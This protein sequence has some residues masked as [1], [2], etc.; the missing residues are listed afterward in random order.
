[1]KWLFGWP[2]PDK[3]YVVN[4]PLQRLRHEM[5]QRSILRALKVNDAT[6]WYWE[7][8]SHAKGP[9]KAILDG[10]TGEDADGWDR[11]PARTQERLKAFREAASLEAC[12]DRAGI[13]VS[14]Y[15]VELREAERRG[16]KRELLQYLKIEGPF[17]VSRQGG[18]VA[19]KLFIPTQIMLRFREQAMK[20]G[21]KQ[22]VWLLKGLPGFDRWF[23]DWTTPK[24]Y[25]GKRHQ[26]ALSHAELPHNRPERISRNATADADQ[27]KKTGGRPSDSRTQALYKFC[28]R[29]YVTEDKGAATVMVLAN[30]LF[31]D[32]TIEEEATVRQCARRYASKHG[33]SLE[34][35]KN[36]QK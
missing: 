3:G 25:R 27:P 36:K 24:A 6:I 14:Q 2:A 15:Y 4:E 29:H 11:L 5:S 7:R 26:I 18:L 31:G 1:L 17:T 23:V 20:E 33:L 12:C 8:D 32:D 10:G 9:I 28:Y 16:V 30:K 35:G 34:F 19:D 21:G 13:S 22:N